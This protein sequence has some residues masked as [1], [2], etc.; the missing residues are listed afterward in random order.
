MD[1]Y[2]GNTVT[3]LWNYAQ[4]Y[5]MN[6]DSFSTQFGP[7]TPGAL[8]LIAGETHGATPASAAGSVENG[9]VYGDPD[10]ILDECGK[11]GV[12]MSGKNVGDALNERGITWGW[13]QGGFAPS[14]EKEGK[15]VCGASHL[16]VGNVSVTDYSPHH[17]PFEYYASTANPHHLPPISNAMI[18]HSDRANHEYDL[19]AFDSALSEGNLPAVSFRR[20]TRTAT[21]AT[22]IRSTNS[23]SWSKRSTSSRNRRSGGAPR[24]SSPTTTPTAGT[25]TSCR[26]S[27]TRR[28]RPS[29]RSAPPVSAAM[30]K[31]IPPRWT[32]A[33]T[34]RASPCW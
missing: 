9:T 11:G 26:R 25:T 12:Q 1:Y 10:P 16:N 23:G 15:A 14:G 33:A 22:R 29:T 2:D 32:A 34:A 31:T 20:S 28:N 7:S 17:N 6:D 27:S 21:R 24:S 8:N 30:S 4:S 5:A 18:G 19:T 13:F 3:A